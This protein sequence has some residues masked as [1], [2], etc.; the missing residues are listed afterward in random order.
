MTQITTDEPKSPQFLHL[1]G[2]GVTGTLLTGCGQ[3]KPIGVVR[4][5]LALLF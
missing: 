4:V 1:A 3:P 2:L 5:Q